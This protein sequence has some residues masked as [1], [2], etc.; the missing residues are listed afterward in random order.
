MN[1]YPKRLAELLSR[2]KKQRSN[3]GD[4]F[5]EFADSNGDTSEIIRL[6][7]NINIQKKILSRLRV[8]M[9]QELNSVLTGKVRLTI[10]PKLS[11][12]NWKSDI[13]CIAYAFSRKGGK[14][15]ANTVKIKKCLE[16]AYGCSCY[17][18]CFDFYSLL[19]KKSYDE[20]RTLYKMPNNVSEKDFSMIRQYV[21]EDQISIFIDDGLKLEYNINAGTEHDDFFR[22]N[23]QI[24]MG[25]NAVALLLLILNAAYNMDDTRPLLMDQPED[26][27]DNSYIFSTLVKEFRKSK[28]KR[29]VIISTHNPNIPV[30]A[31]AENILVLRYNGRH[32]YLSDNGAIDSEKIAGAV[33]EIME[34]GREAIKRRIGKYNTRYADKI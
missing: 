9:V 17:A 33:L 31:D 21:D 34:G 10:K 24:S 4:G 29:Q 16:K 1:T 15:Y 26:D 5:L 19:L 23:S 27:L 11:E 25:Q 8:D 3:A 32:G 22:D 2:I 13:E 30:A 28:Q 7:N 18:G 20:I 6:I 14:D 12:K